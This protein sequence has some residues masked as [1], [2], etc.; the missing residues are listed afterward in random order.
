MNG[1]R[2]AFSRALSHMTVTRSAPSFIVSTHES[3]Q[4]GTACDASSSK[5]IRFREVNAINP[6][7]HFEIYGGTPARLAE[8]YRALFGWEV[9]QA[10]GVDYW[11]IRTGTAEVDSL[12]GGL[13]YRP[14]CLPPSWVNYVKV[15]SLDEVIAQIQSLGGKIL[16]PRTAVPKAAWYAVVQDP[17]GN[18][19]A[20]WQPDSTAFPPPEPD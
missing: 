4:C 11:R 13:T 10:P 18:I 7:T 20:I 16:R 15:A 8:F 2:N 12:S 14:D 17:E 3:W 9:D 19:F 1:F 5:P 6:I